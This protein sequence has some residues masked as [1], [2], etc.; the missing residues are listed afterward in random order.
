MNKVTT[1]HAIILLLLSSLTY[2]FAQNIHR[3]RID[4][5]SPSGYIIPLLLAFTTDNA[6]SDGMDHD[7]LSISENKLNKLIIKSIR[8]SKEILVD[9]RTDLKINKVEI[10][11]ILGKKVS[12]IQNLDVSEV[13]I[14]TQH[15]NSK[16]IIVSVFTNK[17]IIR[18]KKII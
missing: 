12:N 9:T 7:D 18:K 13:R 15:I 17:G 3:V 10:L 4:F 14:S 11:D 1:L 5:Q 8:N 16:I 2:S 6:N